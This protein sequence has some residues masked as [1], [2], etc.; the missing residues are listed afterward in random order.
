[1]VHS[2]HLQ[3]IIASITWHPVVQAVASMAAEIVKSRQRLL[4]AI[5]VA[6]PFKPKPKSGK[7]GGNAVPALF[8][9][10]SPTHATQAQAPHGGFVAAPNHAA[11]D[12]GNPSLPAPK[13][14]TQQQSAPAPA[15]AHPYAGPH[16]DG[17]WT[18]DDSPTASRHR[19]PPTMID[20]KAGS[21]AQ[22]LETN[23]SGG[24]V[25]PKAMAPVPHAFARPNDGAAD[26]R[27]PSQFGAYAAQPPNGDGDDVTPP[28]HIEGYFEA[29]Q[30]AQEQRQRQSNEA[31]AAES[32]LQES[33]YGDYVAGTTKL[34]ASPPSALG[35]VS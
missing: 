9:D 19:Q 1:M 18:A 5:Q 16:H 29:M 6:M 30:R 35:C 7:N 12:F 24:F 27:G 21:G 32:G 28:A 25:S 3:L 22:P 20:D 15:P 33:A 14:G 17:T 8:N 10:E 13:F 4:Q 31:P 11:N 26:A 23:C 2:L 34:I